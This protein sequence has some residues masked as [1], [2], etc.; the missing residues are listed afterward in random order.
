M[1][2]FCL[3]C[4]Y[5][6]EKAGKAPDKCPYCSSVGTIRKDQS[7]QDLLDN[8]NDEISVVEASRKERM[9]R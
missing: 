3:K 8:I 2:Y 4:H 1:G 7:A 9:G 5:K 6:Y